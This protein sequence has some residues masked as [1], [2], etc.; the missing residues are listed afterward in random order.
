[1]F[2]LLYEKKSHEIPASRESTGWESSKLITTYFPND[3][4]IAL[5]LYVFLFKSNLFC[6]YHRLIESE[7]KASSNVTQGWREVGLCIIFSSWLAAMFLCLGPLNSISALWESEQTCKQSKHAQGIE[8][9]EGHLCTTEK[10]K[11]YSTALL[12]FLIPVGN[13]NVSLF[14]CFFSLC[15]SSIELFK[16]T[17]NIEF[18]VMHT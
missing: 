11:Q 13:R 8:D 6:M 9:K 1:M 16:K 7:L 4:C 2:V 14:K 5:F 17:L 12:L 10:L 15:V 3:K 18:T